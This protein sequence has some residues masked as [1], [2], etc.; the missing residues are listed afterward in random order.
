M[1][2][3]VSVENTAKSHQVHGVEVKSKVSDLGLRFGV[4]WRDTGFP[5]PNPELGGEEVLF[6][7]IG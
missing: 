7:G 3:I 4:F 5:L 1:C 2:V 6:N